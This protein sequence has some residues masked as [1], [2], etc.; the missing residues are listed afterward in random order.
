MPQRPPSAPRVVAIVGPYQSGK[1]S[2]LESLL[3]T[4]GALAQRGSVTAGTSLG[5]R[6]PE[7]R[8]HGMG[9]ALNVART[10]WL[11]DSYT[12]LDCP[13]SVEFGQDAQDAL[14]I[15][16]AA[17][18]VCEPA[19][20]RVVGLA[21]LLHLLDER[22]IPHVVFL[23]K[24]D[25][26]TERVKDV[27]EALRTVSARP[28][29]LREV[30]IREG[31][32]IKGFVDLVTEQ[33][34]RFRPGKHSEP[35]PMPAGLADEEHAARE[36]LIE[37][38][39][40]FDDALLEQVL[41]DIMPSAD[42]LYAQLAQD[43]EQDLVV[44][45]MLGSADLSAGVTR[46]MK[47]LRHETPEPQVTGARLGVDPDGQ[48]VAARVFKTEHVQHVGKLSLARVFR[49]TLTSNLEVPLG[50]EPVRLGGLFRLHG[51]EREKADAAEV[52]QVIAI[53]R[54][55]PLRTG[56]WL[57]DP[58]EAT[59]WPAPLDPLYSRSVHVTK[60]ADE[61]K[62][63]GALQSL[64]EDD[65]SL[66]IEQNGA[67]HQLL[68]HGQGELH[69]KVVVERLAERFNLEVETE[70]PKVPYTETIQRSVDQATRFKRQTGGHGQ[71]ADI[72][73]KVRPLA[74]GEGFV[75]D[76]E[77]VGGVV[78]KRFIP[79]V[80]G[81]AEAA[82]AQGPL[83]FPVQDVGVTLYD[84]Q[85]HA[86][87]SSDQAF[88]TCAGLAMREALPLCSPVLLE[89]VMT[90]RIAVP[91]QFS[92]GVQRVVPGRRGHLL[93][94]AARPD[95]PGWDL[96][97]AHIPQ[98]EMHDLIIDLRSVTLGVASFTCTFDHMAELRDKLADDVVAA[99][100]A[101]LDAAR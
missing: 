74:R 40:D 98:A 28:L 66:R 69:L 56:S 72:K 17:V 51:Q 15:C 11:G 65:P 23:N 3:M 42:D 79:S 27:L 71:F 70:R 31:R 101:E 100:R 24:M 22:S 4:T 76:D 45:V 16:D 97:T 67:T 82:L 58:A 35:I 80:G 92:A 88:R 1:T 93:D 57:G 37:A 90:V 68:I 54:T 60:R 53:A 99:R 59:P 34:W 78:P 10:E 63:L 64:A 89:P 49:G 25:V 81:G 36:Q 20:D 39:A 85:Y 26:A 32:E 96:L 14:A 86:V 61:V 30:P 13:G 84:G 94:F 50:D 95:W 12:F 33:A 55:E 38:L 75:F 91:S 73:I 62:L 9:V 7:A 47:L 6:Q 29:V 46:L 8:A 18:V 41:E 87:D 77:I 44:P 43:F 19:A 21:P 2:L 52:G 83:G 5:D 48:G